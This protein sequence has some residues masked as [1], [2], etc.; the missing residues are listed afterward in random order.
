MI[1][2]LAP[3]LQGA[4]AHNLTGTK[5]CFSLVLRGSTARR[6]YHIRHTIDVNLRSKKGYVDASF[7]LKKALRD[8]GIS[9][10]GKER[11][12][13]P[14]EERVERQER[15]AYQME[16]RARRKIIKYIMEQLDARKKED[17]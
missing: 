2:V 16:K 3:A 4:G 11:H 12:V 15:Y 9:W 10:T 1:R 14:K 6:A 5:E 8:D 7:E 17:V 13:K